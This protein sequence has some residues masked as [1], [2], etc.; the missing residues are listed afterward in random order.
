MAILESIKFVRFI[1][2]RTSDSFIATMVVT[3]LRA[4]NWEIHASGTVAAVGYTGGP[5]LF[6]PPINI[7]N[8]LS[9]LLA[10]TCRLTTFALILSSCKYG[11]QAAINSV[12]P[13]AKQQTTLPV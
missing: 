8:R 13:I 2:K 4:W 6:N 7:I 12:V 10:P 5:K 11:Q 9:V 1:T 3:D